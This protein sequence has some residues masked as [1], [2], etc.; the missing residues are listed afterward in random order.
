MKQSPL[1]LT[2]FIKRISYFKI[3]V[4]LATWVCVQGIVASFELA[5][6]TI[7][8][9]QAC[10]PLSLTNTFLPCHQ[11]PSTVSVRRYDTALGVVIVD[12]ECSSEVEVLFFLVFVILNF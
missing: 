7:T 6:R 5:S 12:K 1:I 3:L 11:L 8:K 9:T 4:H 10:P 2:T